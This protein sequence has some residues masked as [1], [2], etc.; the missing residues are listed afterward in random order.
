MGCEA[1]GAVFNTKVF[2]NSL[3]RMRAKKSGFD[4]IGE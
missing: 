2:A 3:P 4:I 1:G